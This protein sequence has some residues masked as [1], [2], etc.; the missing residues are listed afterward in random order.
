MEDS[1]QLKL[2]IAGPDGLQ[3]TLTG[4]WKVRHAL[5]ESAP[6]EDWLDSHPGTKQISFDS[7][8]MSGWDSALLT[9]LVRVTAIAAKNTIQVDQSGLP[10]GV[11]KL[12]HLASAVPERGDARRTAGKVSFLARIGNQGMAVAGTATEALAFLGEAAL[13]LARLLRGKAQFR[14]SDLL[15]TLQQTGAQA[16]G[17]VALIS[18]LVGIILAYIGA[19]QL[20]NFGATMYVADLVGIG[21]ARAMGAMMTGI[22]MAGRTGAAFAAQLGTMQVNEEIDALETLGI[23]AMDFLVLPRM[24]AL[25][26]MMPLL[27][28]YADLF[29]ILGGLF[30]SVTTFDIGIIEYLHRTQEAV[31]IRHVMV[32]LTEASVYGVLVAVA[33]CYQGIK[34][35][36]S[37]SAVGAAATSAVVSGI[38]LIVIATAF[39]TV[40]FNVLGI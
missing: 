12:L 13:S 33:G 17:I 31:N 30:V 6:L 8:A 16:L 10:D 1:Y 14:W 37:S 24:L 18:F 2:A 15:L 34:C 28:L 7:T 11:Q 5:P 40:I 38:L 22:I 35:G 3:I 36:R 9:F 23:S 21:M 27:T 32:G 20:V 26:L 25:I 4:N 29:G 19:A 39:L